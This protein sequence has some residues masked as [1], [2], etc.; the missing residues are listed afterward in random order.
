MVN[1]SVPG[2]GVP[3]RKSVGWRV[4]VAILGLC[5][6]ALAAVIYPIWQENK[7]TLQLKEYL[8]QDTPEDHQTVNTQTMVVLGGFL[9]GGPLLLIGTVLVAIALSYNSKLDAVKL[10]KAF[11]PQVRNETTLSGQPA[12]CAY[13]GQ[14]TQGKPYCVYCGKKV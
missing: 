1:L 14:P 9:V 11:A 10:Q 12:F 4:F 3:R 13:C 5:G 6:I 2:D 8:G 7:D